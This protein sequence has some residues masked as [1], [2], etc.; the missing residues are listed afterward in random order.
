MSVCKE[1]K[2]ERGRMGIRPPVK[3]QILHQP[4]LLAEWGSI[5]VTRLG[6]LTKQCA[7]LLAI[8]AKTAKTARSRR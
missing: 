3:S 6:D 7:E 5:K 8:F 4:E 1:K 2:W